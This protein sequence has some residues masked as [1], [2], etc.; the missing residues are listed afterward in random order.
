MRFELTDNQL[1]KIIEF[2]PN[3]K[4]KY[5]GAIGGGEIYSFMPTSI[6]D[7]VSYT[8]KCGEKIDITESDNW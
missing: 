4:Q 6:G 5:T 2:H 7:C 1:K 8:C 3:C